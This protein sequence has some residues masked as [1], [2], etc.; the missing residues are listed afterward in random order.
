MEMFIHGVILI[1]IKYFF[2]LFFINI[3]FLKKKLGQGHFN[4]QEIPKK[5]ET[6]KGK[7]IIDIAAGAFHS[8]FLTVKLFKK[9]LF[10]FDYYRV[11]NIKI[12]FFISLKIVMN[13]WELEEIM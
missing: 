5:I 8:L 7:K 2:I 12:I 11:N 10:Y 9:N 3:F 1:L 13:Y 6:L 4:N